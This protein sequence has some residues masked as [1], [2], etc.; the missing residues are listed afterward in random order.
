MKINKILAIGAH[1]DDIEISCG[2]LLA[3]ASYCSTE[4]TML[5]LS[6]SSYA[7]YDG[8]VGRTKEVAW[9][10]GHKAADIIGAKLIVMDFPTK[11]IPFNSTSIEAIEEV[12]DNIKP[13]LVITHWVYDSHPSHR[14][15]A[16]ATIAACRYY[17]NILMFEPVMPSGRTYQGFRGQI[18][19]TISDQGLERKIAALK[20]HESQYI[21]YGGDKWVHAVLSRGIHRGFEIGSANAECFEIVRLEGIIC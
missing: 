2:G 21:K 8:K 12:V 7:R 13:N 19:H 4:I 3:D 5:V 10:E 17:N 6:D 1:L 18:Y 9:I 14:N 15:T 16:Q 11:D 20:A